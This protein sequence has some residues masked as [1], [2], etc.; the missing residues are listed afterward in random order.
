MD[1]AFDSFSKQVDYCVEFMASDYYYAFTATLERSPKT[2]ITM[3]SV[4]EQRVDNFWEAYELF[5][6][7]QSVLSDRIEE[8]KKVITIILK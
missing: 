7:P 2:K 5:D 1:I 4:I 6:A 8:Y 3:E